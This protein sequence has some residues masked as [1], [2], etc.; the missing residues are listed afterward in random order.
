M[1]EGK[2]EDMNEGEDDLINDPKRPTSHGNVAEQG[3][4]DEVSDV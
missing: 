3:Y 2:R 1:E 4:E